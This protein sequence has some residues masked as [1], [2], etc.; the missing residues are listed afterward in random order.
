V[1]QWVA[2]GGQDDESPLAAAKRE[3]IEEAGIK[4][5]SSFLPLDAAASI[6]ANIFDDGGL[7]NDDVYVIT[8]YAFGV[9]VTGQALAFAEEHTEMRWLPDEEARELVRYDSNRIALW[10]LHLRIHGLGPRDILR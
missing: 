1:W 9:D 8:E 4:E 2:G 7:W 6:P 3:A 5:T 10:E